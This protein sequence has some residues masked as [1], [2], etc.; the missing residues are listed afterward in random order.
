[1]RKRSFRGPRHATFAQPFD[2]ILQDTALACLGD[3]KQCELISGQVRLDTGADEI[4][5]RVGLDC[6]QLD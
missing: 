5:E 4:A 6:V 1:M 3:L 2:D